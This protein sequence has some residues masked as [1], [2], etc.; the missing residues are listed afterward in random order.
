MAGQSQRAGPADGADQGDVRQ[1]AGDDEEDEQRDGPR[2]FPTGGLRVFSC[3]V[4][5]S[6]ASHITPNKHD[7]VP[8]GIFTSVPSA[9]SSFG[10]HS[11]TLR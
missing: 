2:P 8:K 10:N 1:E 6:L 7:P 4:S 3:L 11:K 5:F 9:R